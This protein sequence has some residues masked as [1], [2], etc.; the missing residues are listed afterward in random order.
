MLLII[1][2]KKKVTSSELQ[3]KERRSPGIAS[4]GPVMNTSVGATV[5][6][7]MRHMPSIFRPEKLNE[8]RQNSTHIVS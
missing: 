6:K 1:N 2:F 7:D 4:E 5:E 3:E 8:D